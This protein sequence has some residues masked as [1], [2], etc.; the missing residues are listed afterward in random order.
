MSSTAKIFC[1]WLMV[2]LSTSSSFAVTNARDDVNTPEANAV[3]NV[4]GCTGTLIT[5]TVV[6]TVGHCVVGHGRNPAPHSYPEV[7]D[8]WEQ[9]G[10]WYELPFPRSIGF[11]N[12][13]A[14][15]NANRNRL[16]PWEAFTIVDKNGDSLVSGDQVNWRTS[17]SYY[18]VA[19]NNGGTYLAATRT[20]PSTWETFTVEKIAGSA[21]SAIRHGDVIAIVY[22]NGKSK[23]YVT[24]EGGGGSILN[25]NRTW[26]REWEAFTLER[27]AGQPGQPVQA[28][29]R[30]ALRAANGQYVTAENGGGGFTYRVTATHYS[31]AGWADIALL[32]LEHPVPLSIARPM[33]V[34]TR[35][36]DQARAN[37]TGFWRGQK[38]QMVGWGVEDIRRRYRQAANAE[39][40][41]YPCQTAFGLNEQ[42][43]CPRNRSGARVEPGDSGSPLIWIDSSG[44][45]Y[46]IAAAQGIEPS[47]GRYTATFY[48]GGYVDQASGNTRPN[49]SAWLESVACVG[50]ASRPCINS[51]R[52]LSGEKVTELVALGNGY[53]AGKGSILFQGNR[54]D[55]Q[56]TINGLVFNIAPTNLNEC[57]IFWVAFEAEEN[58]DIPTRKKTRSPVFQFERPCRDE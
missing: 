6:L 15:V 36:P 54:F 49:I 21:G 33:T 5:S 23:W 26:R 16:G 32:Q 24:A 34:L 28:G 48:S 7:N 30:I 45:K 42:M 3:V 44:W 11:G 37:P 22:S 50:N 12:D 1:A 2:G 8:N 46:V 19:E 57:G 25:V 4:D 47:G 20:V 52:P 41:E 39:Q 18:L 40:G 31:I 9:P 53:P 13:E 27:V 56:S 35:L 58:P 43:M 51:I 38:F 14:G 10:V 29:D 55:T 17:G